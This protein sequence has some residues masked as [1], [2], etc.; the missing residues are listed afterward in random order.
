MF[1]VHSFKRNPNFVNIFVFLTWL[2]IA[3]IKCDSFSD[4]LLRACVG[5]A[6]VLL[7]F[8][9]TLPYFIHST[10]ILHPKLKLTK[11][12]FKLCNQSCSKLFS[13]SANI[14]NEDY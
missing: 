2:V 3:I 1:G 9:C 8:C 5:G 13:I 14:L 11:D 10:K 4:F 6:H 7:L 12:E